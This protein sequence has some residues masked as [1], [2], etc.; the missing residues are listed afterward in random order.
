[1]VPITKGE[2]TID[3]DEGPREPDVEKMKSLDPAF[4]EEGTVTAATSSPISIGAAAIIVAS[5]EFAKKHGI[6]NPV[7]IAAQTMTTDYGSSFDESSMIK[8]VGFDMAKNAASNIYEE[9]GIGI[10][11]V[12]V[13]EL[14]DCFTANEILTYDALGLCAEGEA[15]K[16][17]EDGD[18]T[19]GGK[20]V[21]N[22]SGGLL[23]KGHPLGATGAKLTVQLLHELRRREAKRGLVTMCI[24]GGMGAAGIFERVN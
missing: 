6:S 11:D 13:I 23:S 16:L 15:E 20:W 4:I 17:I 12:D 5:D 19:Y 9:A 21:T 8:M 7:Y 10:E 24:G 3:K 1:M 18:N 22:P 2:E 14:H